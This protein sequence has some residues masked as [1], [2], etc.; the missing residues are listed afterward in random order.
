[1]NSLTV[2]VLCIALA[3]AHAGVVAPLANIAAVA[4]HDSPIVAPHVLAPHVVAPGVLAGAGVIAA[5]GLI[6]SPL[7][8]SGYPL[9]AAGSGIEGQYIHDARGNGLD[10]QYV[11]DFTETLYDN[12]QYHGEIYA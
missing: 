10:G 12:G 5:R 2:V 3:A 9:L 6:A 4:A 11:H 7:T 8:A 1:M